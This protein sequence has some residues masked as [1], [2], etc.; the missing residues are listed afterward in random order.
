MHSAIASIPRSLRE[1][2]VPAISNPVEGVV[3]GVSTVGCALRCAAADGWA[4]GRASAGGH[5]PQTNRL[6]ETPPSPPS[7]HRSAC[8]SAPDAPQQQRDDQRRRMGPTAR[9]CDHWPFPCV[10]GDPS[11]VLGVA[12]RPSGDSGR[13]QTTFSSTPTNGAQG[14]TVCTATARPLIQRRRVAQRHTGTGG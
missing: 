12:M 1:S 3:A 2:R 9:R 11:A 7:P 10:A 4:T 5:R 13:P 6:A 14:G 8:M